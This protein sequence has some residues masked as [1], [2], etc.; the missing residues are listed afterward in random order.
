MHFILNLYICKY[1]FQ[2]G[3]I[4]CCSAR[5][6]LLG[7]YCYGFF[8]YIKIKNNLFRMSKEGDKIKF[9][10]WPVGTSENILVL[11]NRGIF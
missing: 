8:P 5:L 6:L 4:F 7:D 3:S 10:G 11:V 2:K 9:S 1:S